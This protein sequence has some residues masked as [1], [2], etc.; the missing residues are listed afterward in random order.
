M[1]GKYKDIL[2]NRTKINVNEHSFNTDIKECLDS[3]KY[4]ILGRVK[5]PKER[6]SM[7]NVL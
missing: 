5:Q 7:I 2:E 1:K 3:Y 6:N 4:S